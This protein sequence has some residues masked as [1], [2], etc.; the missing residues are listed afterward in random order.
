ME[1]YPHFRNFEF[2]FCNQSAGAEIMLNRSISLVPSV[3]ILRKSFACEMRNYFTRGYQ[4][5]QG[6][7]SVRVSTRNRVGLGFGMATNPEQKIVFAPSFGVSY[8]IQTERTTP[9]ISM[10]LLF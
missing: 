5:S 1:D 7:F 4:S 8:D 6:F 9:F 2:G 10:G 3:S